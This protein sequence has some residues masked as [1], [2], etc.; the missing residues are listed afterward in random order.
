MEPINFRRN[1]FII[2][3]N[4]TNSMEDLST[5]INVSNFIK[6]VD[7]ITIIVNKVAKYY[8]QHL[9]FIFFNFLFLTSIILKILHT[10]AF[11]YLLVM[12]A[13]VQNFTEIFNC[14]LKELNFNFLLFFA[15]SQIL[16][17]PSIF[18]RIPYSHLIIVWLDFLRDLLT[19]L[20]VK[21][22]VV[23]Y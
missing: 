6:L 23:I 7:W 12:V 9:F 17:P 22:T 3:N 8:F 15:F 1:Y 10:L 11:I 2:T 13:K 19:K 20:V 18:L 5:M 4:I 21:R 16:F 14:L